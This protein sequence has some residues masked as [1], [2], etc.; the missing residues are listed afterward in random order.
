MMYQLSTQASKANAFCWL[1]WQQRIDWKAKDTGQAKRSEN[2]ERHRAAG[3]DP[4]H[5]AGLSS[6]ARRSPMEAMRFSTLNWR[7]R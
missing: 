2:I 1:T 4:L 5:I 6:G 3:I 7:R